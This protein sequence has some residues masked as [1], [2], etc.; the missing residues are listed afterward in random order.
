[1]TPATTMKPRKRYEAMREF[2][3]GHTNLEAATRAWLASLSKTEKDTFCY[4]Y[5]RIQMRNLMRGDVRQIEHNVFG[6]DEISVDEALSDRQQLMDKGFFLDDGRWVLWGDATP[7]DH[8]QRAD[9]LH[10]MANGYMRTAEEHEHAADLIEAAGVS[11]LR[12]VPE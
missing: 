8:R 1:M 2:A 5:A 10:K 9:W 3:N 7:A 11:C 6:S 4:P 12:E